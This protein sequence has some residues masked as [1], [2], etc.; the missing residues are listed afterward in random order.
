MLAQIFLVVLRQIS[1]ES[2]A[3]LP[4]GREKFCPG[5]LPG[6]FLKMDE[7]YLDFAKESVLILEKS[8]LF[9]CIDGSNSH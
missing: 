7:K 1:V 8:T 5:V 3:Q 6:T 9:V 4:R 2:G